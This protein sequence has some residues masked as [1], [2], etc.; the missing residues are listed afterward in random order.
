MQANLPSQHWQS[1]TYTDNA[2]FVADYGLSLL[3]WLQ[4]QT[5]ERILDLGCGDGTLTRQ[6]VESG[7]TV[8]GLDGSADFVSAARTSGIDAIQGDGQ[9]LAFVQEFDAVFSNAA[10]HWM[11]NASA[12]ANGVFRALKHGGRFVA[13]MGGKGNI[14][15]IQQ[16]LQ[17]AA[18]THGVTT[19]PCWYFPS[20]AEYTALLE[21][22]G[23]TVRR[24]YFYPRPTPLPTG[25][26]GWLATFA[27]PMLAGLTQTQKV[28]LLNTA[29]A[30]LKQHLPQQ[31]GL[32]IADYVRLRFEAWK[33]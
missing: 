13:E 15:R 28:A 22:A 25:I 33:P 23:F 31:E 16:A 24:L 30:N 3:D 4:A 5:H 29:A 6:I 7:C 32:Y 11:T 18:H 12:V 1:Q 17:Q 20:P 14:S 9:A 19:T 27:Q 8:L 26:E 10:L 21:Q 2:R